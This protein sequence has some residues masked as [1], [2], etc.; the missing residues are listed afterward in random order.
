MTSTD[1]RSDLC[2]GCGAIIP[3]NAP[4][5]QC[6]RCLIGLASSPRLAQELDESLLEPGQV[7]HFGDYE[8]LE[9][10]ARGGMGVVYRARQISLDREVALKMIL[11]GD[12]ASPAT[13]RLF[14][15][16]A[17]AAANL[18]HPHIVPV[19]EIGEHD[20]QHYF[21]MRF[22][23]GG[24]SIADWAKSAR[25]D[26]RRIA[27]V[28]A[29]VAR[30]VAHAHERGVLHRDLKPSNILWDAEAGPQVTDFG[31][32]KLLDRADAALTGSV[33][34][35]GSP[36]YMAPEQADG[37]HGDVTT[38]TDVYGLGAVLYELLSSR[39]PFL[40]SSPLETAKKVVED[41]PT[42]LADVPRDLETICLKCLEKNSARRYPSA[43]ELAEDLERFTRGEPIRARPMTLPELLW[44]W[45]RRRPVPAA[46]SAALIFAILAGITGVLWQ[47]QRAEVAKE[48]LS[49][50]VARLEWRRIV[51]L[52]EDGQDARGLAELAR[53]LR[54]NPT[55]PH[56]PSFAL[57]V[58]ELGGFALP[59]A[60]P[61]DHGP[62][63]GIMR[64]AFSA[65]G[66]EV[67]TLDAEDRVLRWDA[68]QGTPLG[69]AV[70]VP[71][72]AFP[73]AANDERKEGSIPSPDGSRLAHWSPVGLRL[74]ASEGDAAEV[75]C[76]D[77]GGLSSVA[78][79]PDGGR[80]AGG[81]LG[82]AGARIWDAASG[83]ALSP[84]L[85]HFY[86]CTALAFSPDSSVLF[87]GSTEGLVRRW[88]ASDGSVSPDASLV[89]PEAVM[90]L[91]FSPP[92]DRLLVTLHPW[93][94]RT[95]RRSGSARLWDL[96]VRGP[97]L[98]HFSVGAESPSTPRK[99]Y[100]TVAWS[101]DG[102]LCAISAADGRLAVHDAATAAPL[103][104][105]RLAGYPR[106]LAFLPG[107][108]LGVATTGG[109]IV[110]LSVESGKT[111][112]GPWQTHA[113]ETAFFHPQGRL[114]ATGGLG[115]Q[116]E[117]WDLETG[118]VLA[119]AT[120][121]RAPLN[122][123]ALS[124]DGRFLASAGEDGLCI[125][126]DAATGRALFPPLEAEDEIVSVRFSPD[127]RWIVTASHDRSARV[128]DSR[129]GAPRGPALRHEGEVVHASF[130]A[131]G[132]R[133]LTVGREGV[134]RVWDAVSGTPI[135]E[136]MRHR[137]ALRSASFS[138]DDR[139]VLTEDH[140]GLRLW[141]AATGE[142]LTLTL[143]HPTGLGI[144]YDGQGL[145]ALFSPEGRRVLHGTATS[146]AVIWTFPE[147][148]LP[149]PE[150]LPDLLE[151]IGG[152]ALDPLG[153]PVFVPP[154]RW[155]ELQE[156]LRTLEGEGFYEQ[157]ARR[158]AR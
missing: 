142:P 13:L 94:V 151:A 40:A 28:M 103:W 81:F 153:S 29:Q 141:D 5:G 87:T 91:V 39:P 79:S 30:A 7:R 12:F 132:Q 112:A 53:H 88:S 43:L 27:E 128:R 145:R 51:R 10:I 75:A 15:N 20:L 114:L 150:W 110:L 148:P 9:E 111:L 44:S 102:A 18:H 35:M 55:H 139:R 144:G 34:M 92:G 65:D 97:D 3:L 83:R 6:P 38:A 104:E 130:D 71:A 123:V 22:V 105:R 25:S 135:G 11:G 72:S 57:S 82:T 31:L 118:R 80:V 73:E 119:R 16:E 154:Q 155:L 36:S 1:S 33:A 98:R 45:A 126:S 78:W 108:R 143:P 58:L 106:G 137:T 42:R 113:L 117:V 138:P 14:Q 93:N 100:A 32:A 107:G 26:F 131:H 85:P 17:Q 136:A 86:G 115:G 63:S 116:V 96:Q 54:E 101:A 76:E 152:I 70:D 133:V 52:I 147:P 46:L 61:L 125:V 60:P 69:Q 121:H 24:Q 47:W 19:Y 77:S 48:N 146:D 120:S 67:L 74:S 89:H 149:A 124:P 4:L 41:M 90:G 122:G 109:E 156:Q 99:L 158:F 56:A 49:A 21:T 62:G 68:R 64:A 127:G 59:L 23:P 66:E 50:T 84:R 140:Q 134:A 95:P 129:T 2:P 37:R 8:L 157:W